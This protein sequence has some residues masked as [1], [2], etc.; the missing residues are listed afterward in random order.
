M[1]S[2]TIGFVKSVENKPFFSEPIYSLD[3][4][5]VAAVKTAEK[6]G[7]EVTCAS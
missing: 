1:L 5:T 6:S 4:T 7:I 3:P 2:K